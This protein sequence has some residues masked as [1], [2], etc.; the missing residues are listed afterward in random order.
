M[1]SLHSNETLTKT[2]A[3]SQVCGNIVLLMTSVGRSTPLWA[4]S[5]LGSGL[6]LYKSAS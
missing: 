3:D 5:Y 4:A 2:M 6:R 1:V